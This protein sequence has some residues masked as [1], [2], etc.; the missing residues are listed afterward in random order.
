MIGFK[1]LI[2]A[3]SFKN[4]VEEFVRPDEFLFLT[5]ADPQN[6]LY[7]SLDPLPAILPL[8]CNSTTATLA[9]FKLSPTWP[10]CSAPTYCD[11]AGESCTCRV[12]CVE[13]ETMVH[14]K[15]MTL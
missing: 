2:T 4:P 1:D 12:S 13:L 6:F 10:T 15:V 7:N 3:G 5:C 14:L 11:V 9:P 8:F